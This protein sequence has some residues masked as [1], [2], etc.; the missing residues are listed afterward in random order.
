MLNDF[1]AELAGAPSL[2]GARCRGRHS[3]FD[4]AAPDE[5][6]DSVQQ[7]HTQALGLCQHCP[8]L[9]RCADWLDSLPKRK[10]PPGVVAGQI[11]QT[12]GRTEQ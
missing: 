6:P 5:N 4:A 2:P 3:L 9:T 7:R 10:R 8:S 1:F 12:S 11:S